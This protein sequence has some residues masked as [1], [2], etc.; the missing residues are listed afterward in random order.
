MSDIKE[1]IKKLGILIR[2]SDVPIAKTYFDGGKFIIEV[3]PHYKNED[4]VYEHELLHIYRGDLFLEDIETF[5][6]NVASD[7]VIN[8]ILIDRI[9]DELK[10]RILLSC[11]CG[12]QE[13]RQGARVLYEHL[14]THHTQI[15]APNCF[16]PTNDEGARKEAERIKRRILKDYE[17]GKVPPDLDE[18]ITKKAEEEV[19]RKQG[20]QKKAGKGNAEFTL[21]LPPPKSNPIL[22]KIKKHMLDYREGD[23]EFLRKYEMYRN[24]RNPFIKREMEVPEFSAILFVIDVSGSMD[25][26]LNEILSTI[27]Y[28]EREMTVEKIFFSDEIKY[29]RSKKYYNAGSGTLFLPVLK[30]LKKRNKKY[31]LICV[32]S[33]YQFF[34]INA[35]DA[36]REVKK[37]AK[38]LI[39][40]DE[41]LKE[42][43]ANEIIKT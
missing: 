21:A 9:P 28:F 34:D 19:E 27:R 33:D 7:I 6:W 12:F 40:F 1:Y 26:Y 30:F 16:F 42:V 24:N 41:N 3:N 17:E 2:D 23:S 25:R 10:E 18:Y 20:Q 22:N 13:W 35:H 29:T 14:L 31:S 5:L 37:Y 4:F 32:F 38:T 11:P 43:K 8:R 15:E 36:L 39:C